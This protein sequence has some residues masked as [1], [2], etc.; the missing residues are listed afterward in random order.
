MRKLSLSPCFK[1]LAGAKGVPAFLSL[2]LLFALSPTE[3]HQLL[4]EGGHDK[5]ERQQLEQVLHYVEQVHD[6]NAGLAG[7]AKAMAKAL[8]DKKFRR[9]V[10]QQITQS[11][12]AEQILEAKAFFQ[13]A[14]RT[15][16]SA[17][18]LQELQQ[19]V[20]KLSAQVKEAGLKLSEETGEVDIYFPVVAHRK[21]WR[22]DENLLVA[23]VPLADDMSLQE[24]YAWSV[25]DQE[26]VI[27]NAEE[28]PEI[29]T[30]VIA[31]TEKET[32]ATRKPPPP[33][34]V[35]SVKGPEP[36]DKPKSD[37]SYFGVSYLSL[38]DDQEPWFMG[39]PE[40]YGYHIQLGPPEWNNKHGFGPCQ[41]HYT[42]LYWVNREHSSYYVWNYMARYFDTRYSDHTYILIRERD[43]GTRI[44]NA[45]QII[46]QD[47]AAYEADQ[48][49]PYRLCTWPESFAHD[50][51][52]GAGW[53]VNQNWKST[54]SFG[55]DQSVGAWNNTSSTYFRKIH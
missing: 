46:K 9:F 21:H 52:F 27:I 29:P 3:A 54:F 38:S 39:Y 34:D 13:K 10:R 42:D 49:Q 19:G 53:T 36:K 51:I 40:I 32:Y 8:S 4:E 28:P 26:R 6:I 20:L 48:D 18:G 31:L 30:L 12:N 24:I 50:Y 15:N 35:G 7:T 2:T 33:T 37:N 23:F 22:G 1:S 44:I 14:V 5:A 47:Q 17:P 11:R 43:P 16:R 55:P 25:E 45:V 41:S